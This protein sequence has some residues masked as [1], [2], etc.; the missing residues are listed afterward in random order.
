MVHYLP[1]IALIA[2]FI[3]YNS[4]SCYGN[5]DDDD[6]DDDDDYYYYY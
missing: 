4:G 1:F 6:D 5:I 2:E 3:N